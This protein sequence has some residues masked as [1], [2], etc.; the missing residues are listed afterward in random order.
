MR[1]VLDTCVIV[2][3]IK[4]R[5]G[6]SRLLLDLMTAQEITVVISVPL[7]LEYEYVIFRQD[8]RPAGWSDEALQA[9]LDCV[10]NHA[11]PTSIN[12]AYRP[13]LDDP[14]DELVLEAAVNGRADLVTFNRKHFKP[15]TNFGVRVLTP[16]DV[17]ELLVQRR[18]S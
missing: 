2:A 18:T 3:A 4:S 17:L 13:L 15:A 9:V 14:A 5:N 10:I 12:F 11:E 16:S 8:I 6:A 7:L 1:L